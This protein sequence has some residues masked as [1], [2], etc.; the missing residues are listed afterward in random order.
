MRNSNRTRADRRR[1]LG[2]LLL[3]AVMLAG[4]A[5]AEKTGALKPYDAE[6]GY[7]YVLFGRYPQSI[8]GGSP[9]EE[10]NTQNWRKQYRTWETAAR[11]ELKLKTHDPIDPWDPGPVE[12]DP[13]LWRVLSAEEDRVYLMSEY[14]LF[15]SPL[16]PSM[17]EYRETQN[18]FG[19]TDLCRKLNGD[20]ADT[21]F[22]DAEKEA[23]LPFGDY[24]RVSVPAADDLN[25]PAMG[26]S[27]KKPVTRKAKATEFAIRSTGAIVYRAQVGSHTPY[28]LREQYSKDPRHGR[29]TKQDGKVGHL[30]CDAADVGA[31]PVILLAAGRYRITGGSGTREDPYRL[32]ASE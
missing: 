17:T 12:P 27:S 26:F 32:E 3:A 13:L 9:D 11:K 6:T 21:A 7:T 19:K 25:N 31:R 14:I 10:N 23:L 18:D 5:A 28:W 2:A 30:H 16:H 20:F 29:S 8:D 24:G 4:A 22:T 1:L 15:A